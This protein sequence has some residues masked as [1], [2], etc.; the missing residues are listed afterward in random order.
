MAT[1]AGVAWWLGNLAGQPRP[2]FSA[3]VP[4]LVI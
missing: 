1:A 3:L 4:I 2:V